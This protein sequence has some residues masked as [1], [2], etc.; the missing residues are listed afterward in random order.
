MG[1]YNW[2][3]WKVGGFDGGDKDEDKGVL[4]T[5][6]SMVAVCYPRDRKMLVCV[7]FQTKF[8]LVYVCATLKLVRVA[9]HKFGT[10]MGGM[11][12]WRIVIELW[13]RWCISMWFVCLFPLNYPRCMS[14]K[15]PWF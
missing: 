1:E 7:V 4:C 13:G 14:C 3:C 15:R 6:R 8:Q 11:C 12:K 9:A 2:T 10:T 5:W